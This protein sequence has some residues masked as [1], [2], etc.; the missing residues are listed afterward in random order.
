MRPDVESYLTL[1]RLVHEPARLVILTVLAEAEEAEFRF[2]E[3]VCGLTKGNLNGHISKLKEAG[4]VEARK[5]FRGEFP[6]TSLKITH[7]GRKA[8]KKYRK[9][10]NEALQHKPA[11]S[12][13]TRKSLSSLP[14]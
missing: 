8:L 2:L 6:V 3:K 14:S 10:L 1:D 7:S 12:V 5:F 11:V 13:G 9:Q 4:Y